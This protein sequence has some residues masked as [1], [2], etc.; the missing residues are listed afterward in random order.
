M[1]LRPIVVVGML[2]RSQAMAA[3]LTD[4]KPATSLVFRKL[5]ELLDEGA[6]RDL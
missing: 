2:P 1:R 4:H 6:G 3:R 5:M